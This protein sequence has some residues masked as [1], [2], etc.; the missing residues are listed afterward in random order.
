MGHWRL[1]ASTCRRWKVT[2]VLNARLLKKVHDRYKD[3]KQV[4]LY[5]CI[6]KWLLI[7]FVSVENNIEISMR[8]EN[9]SCKEIVRFF[10]SQLF[11]SCHVLLSEFRA[12][13]LLN[14][15]IIVYFFIGSGSHC[16]WIDYKIIFLF[17]IGWDLPFLAA[18][19][20]SS[21]GISWIWLVWVASCCVYKVVSYFVNSMATKMI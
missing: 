16:V 3:K 20:C 2:Y 12:P 18:S 5:L 11:D 19:F 1:L 15:L 10:S 17:W 13:K 7:I 6:K 9:F 21:F 4:Y 14:E 8:N